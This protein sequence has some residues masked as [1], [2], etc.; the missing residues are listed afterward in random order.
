VSAAHVNGP[1]GVS[2]YDAWKLACPYDDEMP[3]ASDLSRCAWPT[4]VA[5]P[6]RTSLLDWYRGPDPIC[7]WGPTGCPLSPGHDG[8]HIEGTRDLRLPAP[9]LVPREERQTVRVPR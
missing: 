8:P 9:P 6:P 1:L 5:S 3:A 4:Q 7:G 2:T